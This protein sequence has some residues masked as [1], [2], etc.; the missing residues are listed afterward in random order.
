[1]EFNHFNYLTPSELSEQIPRLALAK[2]KN[3]S[4]KQTL[5]SIAFRIRIGEIVTSR[6][7]LFDAMTYGTSE[8]IFKILICSDY[9]KQYPHLDLMDALSNTDDFVSESARFISYMAFSL[10]SLA[11]TFGLDADTLP[12]SFDHGLKTVVELKSVTPTYDA[13]IA[14]NAASELVSVDP[15]LSSVPV[16][17]CDVASASLGIPAPAT[18]VE[19]FTSH[20][21]IG[22]GEQMTHQ[23]VDES[24]HAI[25]IIEGDVNSSKCNVLDH[26]P[27]ALWDSVINGTFPS[28]LCCAAQINVV[29]N[30]SSLSMRM[31][32]SINNP[33]LATTCFRPMNCLLFWVAA[34]SCVVHLAVKP[35]LLRERADYPSADFEQWPWNPGLLSQVG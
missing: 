24:E 6:K 11:D 16:G 19:L 10:A 30:A 1:M 35:H 14:S 4:N 32:S 5:R 20:P 9:V 17:Q 7:K 33:C 26:L 27:C 3:A 28:V 21:S 25:T 15:E 31:D 22:G 12:Q 23:L 18:A 34:I 2:A 8:N 29:G 13:F